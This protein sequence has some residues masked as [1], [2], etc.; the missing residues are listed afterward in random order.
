MSTGLSPVRVLVVGDVIV[1]RY[2][3]G[4]ASRLSPEAPVPVLRQLSRRATPGGAANVACNVAALGGIASVIGVVGDDHGAAEL[5]DLLEQLG[6]RSLLL[7]DP[8]RPTISKTRLMANHHQMIR[9]DEEDTAQVSRHISDSLFDIVR[10]EIE[11][12]EIVV[13]SDYAKG[14]LS[15]ELC[16]R[17]I[18]IAGQFGVPTLVDPK[19]PN[20]S[21]FSGATVITPNRSE[22]TTSTGLPCESDVE[23]QA[24]AAVAYAET[25]SDIL[26]TRSER[27]MSFFRADEAPI[28]IPTAAKEVF[29]VSGAGDTVMA[30]L[31][32]GIANRLPIEQVMRIANLAAAIA[33]SKVGTA[34]V[35]GAELEEALSEQSHRAHAARPTH[36]AQAKVQA[37]RESW[38]A[39]GLKVGITNGCFDII[40]PGHVTLLAQAALKCDRLIVALN[41]DASVQRLK[42]PSRP[43]QSQEA[44]A[45]VMSMIKGVD[46]VVLFDEDTPENLIRALSPDVLFKGSDYQVHQIAGAEHVL[47]SGGAV[48]LIDLVAGQ[49]TTRIV[50]HAIGGERV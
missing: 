22:L 17:I 44:R 19:R 33:V 41:T 13:L 45:H 8:S 36:L 23:A 20:W 26:L 6:V 50:E 40:H 5:G 25:G 32:L 34:I 15:D 16:A 11:A 35:T 38:R 1:D 30:A 24:A 4:S 7:K 42:G 27:G 46:A 18:D 29:D 47:S 39:S 2:I 12:A 49:S 28:H 14:T 3:A 48:E 10:S 21:P 9:L 31:S 43:I 37:L